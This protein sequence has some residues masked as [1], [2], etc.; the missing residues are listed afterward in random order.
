ML[1]AFFK[2]VGV[3]WGHKADNLEGEVVKV[4][5]IGYFVAG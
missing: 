1:C 2:K 5:R 3:S 4:W